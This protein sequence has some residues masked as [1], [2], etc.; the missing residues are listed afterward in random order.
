MIK[1]NTK[2]QL[3][4]ILHGIPDAMTSNLGPRTRFIMTLRI[5]SA[6]AVRDLLP[7]ADCIDAMEQAM[8]A[9]S[10][11]DVVFPPRLAAPLIDNSGTLLVMPGSASKPKMYGAKVVSLHPSNPDK[12]RPAIQGFVT[13]FDHEGGQPIAIIEGSSITAIRTAAASGLATRILARPDARSCGILGNGVQA[14]SH[15]AAMAA[16][17]PVEE[18]VVWG[19]NRARAEAV[20]EEAVARFDAR[21]RVTDD[22]AEA[23]ACDIV[24]AVTGSAE[25]V[26][27]SEWVRPGAHINLVGAHSP[28]AREAD[29][30]L[31]QRAAI[32]VDLMESARNE[33]G[34]ILIP[35]GEGALTWDR[36]RGEIGQVIGGAVPG[37]QSGEEIT[38]YKSLGIVAQDLYAARHVLDKAS[39]RDVG[40]EVEF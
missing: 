9:A 12:G 8:A 17:R 11:G 20:V 13:L 4:M 16:A 31:M 19:R 6:A 30:A 36:V 14:G 27:I 32:Y 21:F 26:L 33:A 37:R 1:G 15:I 38:V 40:A 25:P 23:A 18:F 2:N 22:P 3:C 10:N 39:I 34:D 24:C 5:I 35:V 7:M 29:T 28:T